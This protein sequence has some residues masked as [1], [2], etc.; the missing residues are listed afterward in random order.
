MSLVNPSLLWFL[1][2]N[3]QGARL[4]ALYKITRL[5]NRIFR[6]LPDSLSSAKGYTAVRRGR[7]TRRVKLEGVLGPLQQTQKSLLDSEEPW[8]K[9][10]SLASV[11]FYRCSPWRPRRGVPRG[12]GDGARG[13]AWMCAPFLFPA[14]VKARLVLSGF[15]DSFFQVSGYL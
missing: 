8:K 9:L 15:S 3:P 2:G 12:V 13:S 4:V 14:N 6:S 11:V 10:G 1:K 7:S 5:S